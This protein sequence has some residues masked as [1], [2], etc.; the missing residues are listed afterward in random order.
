MIAA[1][2]TRG[3]GSFSTMA[4]VPRRGYQSAAVPPPPPSHVITCRYT[5]VRNE[6]GLTLPFS[7]LPPHGVTLKDGQTFSWPG[8]LEDVLQR[9]L[10]KLRA[11]HACLLNGMLTLVRSPG[12]YIEDRTTHAIKVLG[13]SSGS[14]MVEDP[15]TGGAVSSAS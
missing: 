15:C 12:G 4:E 1:V 5:I 9:N 6:S 2:V 11:Y 13:L 3:Y 14:V 8:N 10:R 7:F